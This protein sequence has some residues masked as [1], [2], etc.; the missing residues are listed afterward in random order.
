MDLLRQRLLA[1]VCYHRGHWLWSGPKEGAA[2]ALFW[3]R[4]ESGPTEFTGSGLLSQRSTVSGLVYRRVL[5][6]YCFL[7]GRVLMTA[8]A[9][10]A[11]LGPFQLRSLVWDCS[12]RSHWLG[13]FLC[14]SLNRAWSH[15]RLWLRPTP[16]EVQAC[17]LSSCSLVPGHVKLTILAYSNGGHWLGPV[18]L[19]PFRC[20]WFRPGPLEGAIS[21]LLHKRSLSHTCFSKDWWLGSGP[22]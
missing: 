9:D 10:V 2:L 5:V 19:G 16:T 12:H 3:W 7:R 15:R 13:L 14:M 6:Q 11:V 1:Q 18:G 17:S 21:D 20:P 22:A 8:L 4:L